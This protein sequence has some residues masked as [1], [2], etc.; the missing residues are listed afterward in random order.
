MVKEGFQADLVLV[1]GNPLEDI[2]NLRNREGVMIRG[3]WLSKEILDQRLSEIA[4]NYG[5]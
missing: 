2:S 3:Q 5:H 4:A 1:Q